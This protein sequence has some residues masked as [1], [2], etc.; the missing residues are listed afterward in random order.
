MMG[1]T[2]SQKSLRNQYIDGKVECLESGVYRSDDEYK[3]DLK[4]DSFQG[5]IDNVD[6]ALAFVIEVEGG[7][8]KNKLEIETKVKTLQFT[9][10]RMDEGEKKYEEKIISLENE[11]GVVNIK[12]NKEQSN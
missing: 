4:Y 6:R 8:D 7:L 1:A 2:K 5:L 9:K 11:L 3:F 12:L 10:D